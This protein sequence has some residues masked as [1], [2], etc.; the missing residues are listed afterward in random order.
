MAYILV[1]YYSRRGATAEMARLIGR[2]IEQQGM[3]AMLRTVPAVS[4][5]SEAS[6]PAVP[7][8]GAAYVTLDD[9]RKCS[10]LALGS[11]TRFGN[12][13]APMK[14][15]LETTSPLWLGGEL[16]GKPASVFTSTSSLHGGH[17]VTLLSMMIPLLHLGMMVS[18]IPYSREE[19]LTTQTGGTPY[20]VSH[21]AG[22]DSDLPLSK[23][24]KSLCI[25]Q[26]SRLADFAAKL[27]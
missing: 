19:L 2:G 7:E 27:T 24:E 22:A 3:E 4:P 23:E 26:G 6:E 11:P 13:A 16:E 18:G 10:G 25:A 20:G 12:M 21:L 14:Y 8:S 17:E 15:F 9:L 1:L 5:V